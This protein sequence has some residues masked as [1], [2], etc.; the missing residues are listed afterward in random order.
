MG[1]PINFDGDAKLRGEIENWFACSLSALDRDYELARNQI[2]LK[3]IIGEGQFGDVHAGLCKLKKKLKPGTKELQ[4][5]VAVKT[6]KADADLA[7]A[8]KFL[9]EACKL[10]L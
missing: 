5:P 9:E 4:I 6:C 3:E 2:E 7:M 1:N 8:D 10:R